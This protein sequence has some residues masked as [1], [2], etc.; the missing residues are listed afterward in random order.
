MK[1]DG[2]P[3]NSRHELN[4][5]QGGRGGDVPGACGDVILMRP[6]VVREVELQFHMTGVEGVWV[7]GGARAVG[8]EIAKLFLIGD[9]SDASDFSSMEERAGKEDQGGVESHGLTRDLCGQDASGERKSYASQ[10]L[11]D[12]LDRHPCTPEGGGE[13]ILIFR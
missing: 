12:P 3:Y 11:N 7:V 2:E 1:K 13:V 5:Q 8:V 6:A 10:P 4:Y 9:R